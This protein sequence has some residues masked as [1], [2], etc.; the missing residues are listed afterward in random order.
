MRAGVR[1]FIAAAMAAAAVAT[2]SSGCSQQANKVPQETARVTVNGDTRTS[3]AVS[4]TQ[5]QWLLTVN[6]TTGPA[7]LQAVLRLEPDGP[8]PQSVNIDDFNGFTG[9]AD[10]GVGKTEA[11][12]AAGTYHITGTAR[13]SDPE[14]PGEQATADFTIDTTC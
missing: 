14:K 11:T 9:V 5:I 10:T 4:C 2:A 3:H 8:N 6:I 1:P 13:G 7:Q 12:F